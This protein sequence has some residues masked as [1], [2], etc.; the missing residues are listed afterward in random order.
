LTLLNIEGNALFQKK[1]LPLKTSVV[2]VD[3]KEKVLLV[4]KFLSDS[5]T[6]YTGYDFSGSKL[7]END[8]QHSYYLKPDANAGIVRLITR[9]G[10]ETNKSI[11]LKTGKVCD[12][13][14][15]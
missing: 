15:E 1:N 12:W 11:D 9:S 7:W 2:L 6:T 14:D 13:G 8:L 5:D 10:G 3:S 4:V